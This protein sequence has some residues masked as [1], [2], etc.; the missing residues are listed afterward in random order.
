[1]GESFFYIQII[2]V[3]IL[4]ALLITNTMTTLTIYGSVLGD[5][6]ATIQILS[7]KSSSI[8]IVIYGDINFD[9]CSR[10]QINSS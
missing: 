2:Y 1:M 6:G 9:F 10:Y 5:S 3:D 8:V 7:S 4:A